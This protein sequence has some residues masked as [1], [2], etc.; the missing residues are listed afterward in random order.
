MPGA[1]GPDSGTWHPSLIAH[2][3]LRHP[4]VGQRPSAGESRF[5]V[6][7]AFAKDAKGWETYF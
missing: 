7:H 1:P 4:P 3:D 6:S 2:M 5:V